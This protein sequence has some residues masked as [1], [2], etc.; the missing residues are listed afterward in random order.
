MYQNP[1]QYSYAP[2]I[3]QARPQSEILPYVRKVYSLFAGGI[4]F[5]IAGALLALYAAGSETAFTT[6]GERI[7][8]PSMVLFFTKNWWLGLILFFGSFFAA[9]F[10]RRKPGINVAALFGFTFVAGLY[11][12]PMLFFAQL[13]AK[14]YSTVSDSPVLH[15][16]LLTGAAFTGLT[17]YVFITRKNFSFL[18]AA[19]NM[20]LWV[21]FGAMI[22]SF[23]VHAQILSLAIASVGV[24]LFS[25]YILYDTSRILHNREEND[26][27]GA[28]LRLFLDVFNV[29]IFLVRILSSRRS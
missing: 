24:L 27:V 21:L 22:L 3:A 11:I 4:A 12:A 7:E 19:L 14:M 8:I 1:N 6:F 10:L 15:A 17:A 23:F 20:G 29:F 13:Q 26:P 25:G 18:G 16:F 2:G 5:T 28:A 9:S